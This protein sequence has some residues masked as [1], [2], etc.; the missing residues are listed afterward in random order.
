MVTVTS[1][2]GLGVHISLPVCVSPVLTGLPLGILFFSHSLNTFIVDWLAF[3]NCLY[4]I[5][6]LCAC[7]L[8][9]A[10]RVYPDLSS[11]EYA[12][13]PRDPKQDKSYRWLIDGS[14]VWIDFTTVIAE[15]KNT[16]LFSFFFFSPNFWSFWLNVKIKSFF[17]SEIIF[18]LFI[19]TR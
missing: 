1:D 11:E 12:P 2:L 13:G 9:T 7:A 14:T 17:Y 4:C 16:F 10:S 3:P 5:V 15:I 6:C 18:F 19:L 8:G